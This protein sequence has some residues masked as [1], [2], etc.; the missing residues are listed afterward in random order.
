MRAIKA[1]ALETVPPF[2]LLWL[3]C[4]RPIGCRTT[5]MKIMFGQA[6]RA[7]NGVSKNNHVEP[8][9]NRRRSSQVRRLSHHHFCGQ[10]G[11]IIPHTPDEFCFSANR[12]PDFSDLAAALAKLHM[13]RSK[14]LWKFSAR[15]TGFSSGGGFASTADRGFGAVPLSKSQQRPARLSSQRC[16]AQ[17]HNL[18]SHWLCSWNSWQ[19]FTISGVPQCFRYSH[20]AFFVSVRERFV[21]QPYRPPAVPFKPKSNQSPAA[22]CNAGSASDT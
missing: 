15:I 11:A 13:S 9:L 18:M 8:A 22:H 3:I 10:S 1:V 7:S 14:V 19:N 2:C 6:G 20:F 5:V 16:S 12:T 17:S 4:M 21:G